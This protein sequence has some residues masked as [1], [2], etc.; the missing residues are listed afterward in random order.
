MVAAILVLLALQLYLTTPETR[1]FESESQSYFCTIFSVSMG[2]KVFFGNNEDS[3]WSPETSFISFIP[4]QTIY[5]FR[6]LPSFGSSLDIYGQVIVGT[7]LREEGQDYYYA[8]GGMNDQGLCFD[9]NAIPEQILD[10]ENAD[11][12]PLNAH[13]DILWHCRTVE[14]VINWYETHPMMFTIWSGQW[15]YVDSSGDGVVVTATDGELVFVRKNSSYLVSTNFN[16]AEPS[17]HYFDYP[18]YRYDTATEMLAEIDSEDELTIEACRDVLK[19]T[20]FE[21]NIFDKLHTMYSTIYDAISRDIYLYFL[22]DF[23]EVVE[24]NLED[25]ISKVDLFESN[26][27]FHSAIIDNTYLMKNFFH[28]T[29]SG[30]FLSD[31]LIVFPL[32]GGLSTIV[33]IVTFLKKKKHS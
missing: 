24:F 32:I 20:H 29:Y 31:Y 15:N 11:W 7:V 14:D 22:H 5:N 23:T 12:R 26:N 16:L 33:I 6:N 4:P 18:C 21:V 17:S 30:F 25:E 8:Q 10:N 27:T 9:A 3:K 13:W 28:Y 19:A 1:S 2:D